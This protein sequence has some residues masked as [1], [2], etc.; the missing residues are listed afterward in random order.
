MIQISSKNA[1]VS[2]TRKSKAK[3]K[4][5]FRLGYIVV[6]DEFFFSQRTHVGLSQVVR[7]QVI[8]LFLIIHKYWISIKCYKKKK[9]KRKTRQVEG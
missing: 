3:Y 1:T 7:T 4:I 8:H 9:I 2:S 5:C 6:T